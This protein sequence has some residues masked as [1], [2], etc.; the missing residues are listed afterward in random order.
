MVPE[1]PAWNDVDVDGPLLRR[2]D[3][4]EEGMETGMGAGDNKKAV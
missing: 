1:K 3:T 2:E 4:V